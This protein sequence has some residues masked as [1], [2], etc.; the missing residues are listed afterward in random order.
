VRANSIIEFFVKTPS[1]AF[2]IPFIEETSDERIVQIPS[3]SYIQSQSVPQIL[4]FQ[5]H[6]LFHHFRSTAQN[7]F[8][9]KSLTEISSKIDLSPDFTT[10][11]SSSYQQTR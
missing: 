9:G 6:I 3:F 4:R 5:N 1:L 10:T 2:V 7:F 8:I 11:E